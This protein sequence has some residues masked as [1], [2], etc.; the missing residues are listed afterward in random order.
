MAARRRRGRG[1]RVG[2]HA[3][4]FW[5]GEAIEAAAIKAS[6]FGI[7]ETMAKCI[8]D[9]KPNT[10]VVTG[11]LQG[12]IRLEPA[13]IQR[14]RVIGRWGSFDINYALAVEAGHDGG[15]EEVKAHRRRSFTRRDGVVVRAHS[16]RA[17][18]RR[19][20]PRRGRNMLRN[21]ADKE[22]PRLAGRIR[23]HFQRMVRD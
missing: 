11:A 4:L 5:N 22:Y 9:A 15:I 8:Q 14:A 16:V 19:V 1:K 17:H 21:A 3:R 12:S 10:P 20:K 2:R 6:R 7:D 23:A 13:R 18:T